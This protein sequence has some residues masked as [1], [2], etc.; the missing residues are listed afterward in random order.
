[1]KINWKVRFKSKSF[2]LAVI[3]AVALVIQAVMALFGFEY[4]F[5]ETVNKLIVIVNTIFA[6][7]VILGVVTDPTT[8]GISDS[9]YAMTKES[10]KETPLVNDKYGNGQEFTERNDK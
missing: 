6:L 7:L 5:D 4:N 1:M 10:P 9:D 3:P 8:P 2:W